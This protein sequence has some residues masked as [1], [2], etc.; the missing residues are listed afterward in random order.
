MPNKWQKWLKHCDQPETHTSHLMRHVAL[1]FHGAC[2]NKIC[3]LSTLSKQKGPEGPENWKMNSR[4]STAYSW[5]FP[6]QLC[7]ALRETPR[8]NQ[9]TERLM[10]LLRLRLL[11][12]VFQPYALEQFHLWTIFWRCGFHRRITGHV[13]MFPLPSC[14]TQRTALMPSRMSEDPGKVLPETAAEENIL[15]NWKP[16][17]ELGKTQGE[18]MLKTMVLCSSQ[19]G[20][21]RS[22][23]ATVEASETLSWAGTMELEEIRRN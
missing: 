2:G 19:T 21:T 18:N 20:W 1:G 7:P 10:R 3:S 13:M 16:F 22:G 23:L 4:G 11:R 12:F 17:C 6:V 5:S 14:W 9:K 8:W 15:Q